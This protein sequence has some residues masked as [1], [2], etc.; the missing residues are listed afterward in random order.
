MTDLDYTKIAVIVLLVGIIAGLSYLVYYFTKR[1]D[2]SS[3]PIPDNN[4]IDIFNNEEIQLRRGSTAHPS[5]PPTVRQSLYA[6]KG[7]IIPSNEN[8]LCDEN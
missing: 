8:C 1:E 2:F 6:D 5:V 3:N 4:Y 7:L